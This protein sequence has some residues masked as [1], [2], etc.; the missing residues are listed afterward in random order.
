MEKIINWFHNHRKA[1][2][3][4]DEPKPLKHVKKWSLRAVV[5]E[6]MAKE[7]IER[8]KELAEAAGVLNTSLKGNRDYLRFYPTALTEIIEDLDEDTRE[9]YLDLADKRN[10]GGVPPL[11]QQK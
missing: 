10:D 3:N 11:V 8:A 1:K 5:R 4:D 9:E 7:V 2:E 6:K